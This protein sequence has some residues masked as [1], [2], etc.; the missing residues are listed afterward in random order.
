MLSCYLLSQL[1]ASW[2]EAWGGGRWGPRG[3]TTGA[4]G[5]PEPQAGHGEAGPPSKSPQRRPPGMWLAAKRVSL[6]GVS[7]VTPSCGGGFI[8]EPEAGPGLPGCPGCPLIRRAHPMRPPSRCNAAGGRRCRRL[9]GRQPWRG[10]RGTAARA[11]VSQAQAR[12]TG[13]HGVRV[14]S[15]LQEV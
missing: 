2:A 11:P 3:D 12:D 1:L 13:E 9:P 5:G 6:V 7:P 8:T 10:Q 14:F 15:Q 4:A